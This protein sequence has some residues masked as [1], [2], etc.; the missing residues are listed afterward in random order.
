MNKEDIKEYADLELQKKVLEARQEEIKSLL[1]S[2]LIELK[3]D[4]VESD[5]GSFKIVERNSWKY[6]E[7]VR[8]I[9]SQ[10]K[11]L[12]KVEELSGEAT[13]EKKKSLTFYSIKEK[14]K[15]EETNTLKI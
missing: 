9:E 1:L 11:D 8:K 10:V 5:F 2:Q 14:A 13:S 15:E 6:S 12:K 4:K 3:A 7:A